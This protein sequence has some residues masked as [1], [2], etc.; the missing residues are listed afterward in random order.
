MGT[1]TRDAK[2]TEVLS[3]IKL[4]T[5]KIDAQSVAF[6]VLER[7][8]VE[9]TAALN[10]KI[11]AQ[12][13]K[14]VEL[15]TKL[16]QDSAVLNAKIDAQSASLADLDTNLGDK[17]DAQHASH[18]VLAIKVEEIEKNLNTKMDVLEARYEMLRK[19]NDIIV[20]N[21]PAHK[22]EV[23]LTVVQSIIEAVSSDAAATIRDVVFS[24]RLKAKE[25]GRPGILIRFGSL[26]TKSIFMSEYFRHRQLSLADLGFHTIKDRVYIND[27]L[28]KKTFDLLMQA[29]AVM[30]SKGYAAVFHRGGRI[31]VRISADAKATPVASVS[32]LAALT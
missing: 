4:L 15:E 2:L 25:N 11:E 18:S 31:Y 5:S 12:S 16:C 28:P 29:K 20:S 32:E 17:I 24:T 3:G 9:Q 27:N 14:Y 1:Q 30:K 19:Q 6:S 21:V 13:A 22:D 7:K 8:L 26:G 23:L 10:C